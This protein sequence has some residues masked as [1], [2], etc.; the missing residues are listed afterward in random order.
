MPDHV[1]AGFRVQ[2]SGRQWLGYRS[3]CPRANRTLLGHNL[4][5][6]MLVGR[7]TKDG[8]VEPLV[9]IE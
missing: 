2:V 8:L 6:E 7:F 5:T 4:S 9:E 1:A 3:L